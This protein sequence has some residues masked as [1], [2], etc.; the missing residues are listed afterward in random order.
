[1]RPNFDLV[2]NKT[3]YAI[4]GELP[5]LERNDI[6][7]DVNDHLSTVTISGQLKRLAPPTRPDPGASADDIGVVHLGGVGHGGRGNVAEAVAVAVTDDGEEG[8]ELNQD[9]HWHVTEREVGDFGRAF[10][11]PVE[12]V[13]MSAV[14]AS[15]ANGILC[16]LVPK[17]TTRTNSAETRRVGVS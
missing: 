17:R 8:K 1:V 9:L 4:Y 11:F 10:Q 3:T 2:E 13:D 12:T 5:G 16:V 15:V 14:S 6:N 7:V